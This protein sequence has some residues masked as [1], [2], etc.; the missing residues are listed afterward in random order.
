MVGLEEQKRAFLE[1][2]C[3]E[4]PYRLVLSNPVDKEAAFFKIRVQR[5]QCQQGFQYQLEKQTKKQVFHINIEENA[6]YEA[7]DTYFGKEYLQISAW[8]KEWEY[9]GKISKRGKILTNRR[10]NEEQ[11]WIRQGNNEKKHYELSEGKPIPP[12]VDLGIFTKEGKV[13]RSQYDKYRQINRFLELVEDVWK[14]MPIEG[15]VH[16]VDF[17][18]GKSYL[19]FLLYYYLVEIKK[20]RWK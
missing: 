4:H 5:I 13:V 8:T 6:L 11:E 15:A 14:D 18:C 16:I 12:L 3:L 20:D 1:S 10:K 19:T 9:Q 17:G 2:L 7:L